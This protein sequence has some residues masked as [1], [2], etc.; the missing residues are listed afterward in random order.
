MF[1][2]TFCFQAPIVKVIKKIYSFY[3]FKIK[4]SLN[5]LRNERINILTFSKLKNPIEGLFKI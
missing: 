5:K 1:L 3:F 2:M 4:H